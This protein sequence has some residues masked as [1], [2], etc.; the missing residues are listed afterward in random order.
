MFAAMAAESSAKMTPTCS[1][2][3]SALILVD[4]DTDLFASSSAVSGGPAGILPATSLSIL[5]DAT[6]IQTDDGT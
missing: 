6:D 3:M 2:R 5:F 4:R 1:G